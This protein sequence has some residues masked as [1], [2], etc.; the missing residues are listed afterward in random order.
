MSSIDNQAFAGNSAGYEN[1]GKYCINIGG[2]SGNNAIRT[3]NN[4]SLGYNTDLAGCSCNSTMLGIGT[5]AGSFQQNQFNNN[6]IAIGGG[7]VT[8]L[9]PGMYLGVDVFNSMELFANF[10]S[11]ISPPWGSPSL[12]LSGRTNSIF[13]TAGNNSGFATDNNSFNVTP[14]R[15]VNKSSGYPNSLWYDK[16][17]GEITFSAN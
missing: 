5:I 13:L 3:G 14:I 1:A 11:F 10:A 12:K 6:C 7:A 2:L 17:T 15:Q 8:P 9:N 16:T 4:I